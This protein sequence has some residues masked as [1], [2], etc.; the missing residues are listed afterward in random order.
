MDFNMTANHA[1]TYNNKVTDAKYNWG[2]ASPYKGENVC[3]NKQT[4]TQILYLFKSRNSRI[5]QIPSV[6]EANE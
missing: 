2:N 1:I 6:N 3:M 5:Y 4:P